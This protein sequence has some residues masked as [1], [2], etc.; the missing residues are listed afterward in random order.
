MAIL[1]ENVFSMFAPKLE[2]NPGTASGEA[3]TPVQHKDVHSAKNAAKKLIQAGEYQASVNKLLEV[4][5]IIPNDLETNALL[6]ALLLALQQFEMAEKFLYKAAGLSEWKDSASVANLAHSFIANNEFSLARK[7]LGKG[8]TAV[9]NSDPS[10][11]LSIAMGDLQFKMKEYSQAAQWYL[12]A[13]LSKPNYVDTWIKAS[14]AR[15]PTDGRNLKFAEN[16]LLQ[17]LS[18]NKDAAELYF[19]LGLVMYESDR[20]PEALTFYDQAVRLNPQSAEAASAY[21]T[22]LHSAGHFQAA[23]E[24]YAVAEKLAPNNAVL[25]ANYAMLMQTH[26]EAEQGLALA[27]RAVQLSPSNPDAI[28]ALRA[29]SGA[30]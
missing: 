17:G 20:M 25:L 5:E 30:A 21:A 29:L 19:A 22:A 16:V 13:A 11:S 1:A 6:G 9:G 15:Y 14:T 2:S 12:S 24:M 27:R 4:V 23:A 10:G 8:L 18:V 7:V 28:K 3:L 26:G